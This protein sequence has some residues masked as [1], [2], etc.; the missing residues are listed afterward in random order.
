MKNILVA[1]DGSEPAGHALAHAARLAR[2]TQAQ[3]HLAYAVPINP[4]PLEITAHGMAQLMTDHRAWG[5]LLVEKMKDE[6]PTDVTAITHVRDG[7]PVDVINELAEH[8]SAEVV[9]VGNTGRGATGRFLLGSTAD[10][11]VHTCKRP[12]LVVR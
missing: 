2:A 6:L 3:L 1:V 9:V 5:N 11:L 10:R 4:L 8:L 12:V 7:A